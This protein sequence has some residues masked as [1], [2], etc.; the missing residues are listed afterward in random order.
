ML[1]NVLSNFNIIDTLNECKRNFV[2]FGNKRSDSMLRS[3]QDYLKQE[4][5]WPSRNYIAQLA[6]SYYEQLVA[7][8]WLTSDRDFFGMVS[9]VADACFAAESDYQALCGIVHSLAYLPLDVE[10]NGTLSRRYKEILCEKVGQPDSHL[11]ML[12]ASLAAFAYLWMRIMT[13][14]DAASWI[15]NHWRFKK[16]SNIATISMSL[17]KHSPAD[18]FYADRTTV[19]AESEL[20]ILKW[21]SEIF[22][23]VY[24]RVFV[25]AFLD[26]YGKPNFRRAYQKFYV[27]GCHEDN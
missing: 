21:V 19:V 3:V 10:C 27:G 8:N 23:C 9:D 15:C 11:H 16:H 7:D 13:A 12:A 25:P 2:A 26:G 5:S 22:A 14:D 20:R 1:T 17:M 18:Y 6:Y 4:G 24:S